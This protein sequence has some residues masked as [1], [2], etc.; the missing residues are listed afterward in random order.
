MATKKPETQMEKRELL[1]RRVFSSVLVLFA[2]MSVVFF[3]TLGA[4][5]SQR[6]KPA[7][8]TTQSGDT[9][10]AKNTAKTTT[11]SADATT[12]PDGTDT[13]EATTKTPTS[14]VIYLTFDDGPGEYTE[15]LLDILDKYNVKVTFFVTNVAS[16]YQDLIKREAKSGHSVG[17]HSYTHNYEKIYQSVEAFWDDFDKMQKVIKK[18]TGSET[19]LMRFPGGSSNTV[20][21]FNPGI[22]TRLT[23]EATEKG[24]TY[25]DWN[26][27]SGDAGLTTDTNVVLKTC[28]ESVSQNA[29][30]VLL[31]HDTKDFTVNAMEAFISWALKNGYTFLPLDK[32]SFA[33][34]HHVNN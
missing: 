12:Q 15:Q 8:A 13:S 16:S 26:A 5:H 20:S 21:K 30:T 28:K 7:D 32:D 18:Q 4:R 33:A 29:K 31:C 22:M 10:A 23:K 6:V 14:K 24:L 34:H 17:V 2:V 19:A 27:M 25:F 3:T 1:F 11:P 9:T